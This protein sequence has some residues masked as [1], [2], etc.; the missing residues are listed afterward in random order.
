MEIGTLFRG[1]IGPEV[2][3]L[4][5]ALFDRGL[6]L[7]IIDGEFGARTEQALRAFQQKENLVADGVAGPVTLRALGLMEDDTQVDAMTGLSV[8]IVSRMCPGARRQN[9]RT[10]LPNVIDALIAQGLEN[11]PM[12][13]VAIATIRTES[14][15]FVP[16]SEF[17]SDLNTAPGGPPF[18][19]YEEPHRKLGNVKPGDGA[20]FRGRGF[21][22][23][24]GRAN[25]QKFGPLL[26]PPIDLLQFP[27]RAN[28]SRVAADLLCLF[29]KNREGRIK[30]ALRAGDFAEARSLV[31]GGV[32][33][34]DVFTESFQT[35]ARLMPEPVVP[36]A[37]AGAVA[38]T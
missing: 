6:Y 31:N 18:G 28:E 23:L 10:H 9:I 7:D 2:E 36:P 25:Y 4:Q 14:A 17:K 29:L 35:G 27:E 20:L 5:R 16:I 22:Q 21:I 30:A 11:R 15:G 3:Q 8:E 12:V 24:T 13:L 32:H 38:P 37:A 1:A 34:V 19:K 33:G 26:K